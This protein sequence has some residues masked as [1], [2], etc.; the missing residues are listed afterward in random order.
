MKKGTQLIAS[1]TYD[2]V[3]IRTRVDFGNST[4]Q[5]FNYDTD[6]RYRL[7]NI[8]YAYNCGSGIAD[9][10]GLKFARDKAGNPLTWGDIAGLYTRAYAY[11]KNSRLDSANLPGNPTVDYVYD[12]VGN[13]TSPGGMQYN[14]ADQ[15]TSWP[16]QHSYEYWGDG[17]LRYQ[18]DGGGVTQKTYSYTPAGLLSSVAHAGAGT[19]SMTRDAGANRIGFTSSTGGTYT[20]VYDMT[21]GI[22]AVTEEVT[23]TGSVYDIREPS[24]AL[25]ARVAGSDTLDHH[26][27]DL[28]FHTF[29]D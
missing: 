1:Y 22:P 10:G 18:K 26:F 13:R 4:W 16:G 17:S 3:G 28:G 12:W 8:H 2:P 27:D 5:T 24:G 6:P 15:L 23:P 21:A 29:P 9:Q 20:F 25:I 19:S 14:A 7:D 11:D